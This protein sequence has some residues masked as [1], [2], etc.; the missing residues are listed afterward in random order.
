M[1]VRSY[2]AEGVD[3]PLYTS[4]AAHS[5]ISRGEVFHGIEYRRVFDLAEK[6]PMDCSGLVKTDYLA[7][8]FRDVN[9]ESICCNIDYVCQIVL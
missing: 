2:C 3:R 7:D 9:L 8:V 6:L 1:S 5:L 4:K